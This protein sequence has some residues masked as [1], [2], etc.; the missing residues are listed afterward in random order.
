MASKN[1]ITG[2]A[3][4]TKATSDEY[5]N[6]FDRIFGKGQKMDE[7]DVA[8]EHHERWLEGRIAEH[9]YQL[10]QVGNCRDIEAEVCNGCSYATK[11]AWGK[12]CDSWPECRADVVR[13]EQADKRNMGG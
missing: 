11:A 10:N 4:R 9:Q 3:L 12:S 6:N 1:C 2:D 5:R 13:R 7:A 8:N